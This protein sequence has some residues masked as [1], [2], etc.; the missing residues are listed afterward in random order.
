[1]TLKKYL[2]LLIIPIWIFSSCS[3]SDDPDIYDSNEKTLLMY[4]PWSSNL[5]NYFYQNIKDM[6]SCI[7]EMG[8]L[9]NERVVV[10]ISMSPTEASM[11]EIKYKEG[12]CQRTEIKTYS[13]LE[14]TTEEGI[15]GILED[16]I[17]YAPAN[18]YSMIVGCH[19]MGWLPVNA[20]RALFSQDKYHWDYTD[21]PLTR[22]F[23]G[24][25]QEFQ[26]DI[27]TLSA[28]ISNTGLKMEYIL[29]DDCYMSSIEVAYELKD[30]ANYLIAS[31]CEV[32]AYGMP[33]ATMGKHLLGN[34]DYKAV[35]EDFYEF[36]STYTV[37]CGT[38]S[39]TDL[40]RIE[41]MANV[42]KRINNS[43]SF[44]D[45]SLGKLQRLDGYSPTIFYDFGDYIKILLEQNDAPE[46]LISEFNSKLNALIP[47]KTNTDHFYTATR[48]PIKINNYSGITT[49][50]PSISHRAIDKDRTAWYYATH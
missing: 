6:E 50:D 36:Y 9:T 2:Y 16:V 35:C 43:Y 1:M 18:R 27:S 5:T 32:M 46:Y 45:G 15:T 30:A 29:F 24:T 49:S 21:G 38:L 48:G 4:M 8:G 40:S 3:E 7:E 28:A 39:V 12:S 22:F 31:T 23:G 44:D 17:R 34:P 26:T 25:T 41:D 42:M 19:G 33:Y 47:F 20:S 10:F 13:N 11:F 14:F 37:P